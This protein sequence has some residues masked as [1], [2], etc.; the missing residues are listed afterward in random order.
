MKYFP[1]SNTD[2][3][4]MAGENTWTAGVARGELV[5]LLLTLGCS[6][7]RHGDSIFLNK[8]SS[9]GGEDQQGSKGRR[10]EQRN[11]P[12][13]IFMTETTNNNW[14]RGTSRTGRTD[15]PQTAC[16]SQVTADN[17]GRSRE[18]LQR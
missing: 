8:A 18:R 1:L 7:S 17:P 13:K 12:I 11:S 2:M 9:R 4:V 10:E 6:S 15:D 16:L 3:G 14:S 5:Y